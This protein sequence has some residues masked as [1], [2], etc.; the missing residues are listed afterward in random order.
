VALSSS[1]AEYIAAATTS[2]Q[3]VWLARLLGEIL[4]SEV[5]RPEIRID[6]KSAISLIKNP[7]HHDRSKHIDVRFHF[8]RECAHDR[9]IEVNFIKT[10][11]QLGDI[12]TKALG[13]AK[14][15]G[16]SV[17]IGLRKSK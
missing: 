13:K 12:L 6:N 8:L 10:E 14:F 7:V 4:D 11:G 5:G 15:E 1:E 17:K 3:G 9:L 16:L 2:C